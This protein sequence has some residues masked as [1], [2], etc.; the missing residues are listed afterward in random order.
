MPTG[1]RRVA[2]VD[3]FAVTTDIDLNLATTRFEGLALT[4][5]RTRLFN[6]ELR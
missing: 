3:E 4:V 5:R 2:D 1:I 6:V